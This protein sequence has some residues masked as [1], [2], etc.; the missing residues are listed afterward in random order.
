[1]IGNRRQV[2]E[3]KDHWRQWPL[4]G[5]SGPRSRA[6]RDSTPPSTDASRRTPNVRRMV[7]VEV[8]DERGIQDIP[9]RNPGTLLRTVPLPVDEI[10]VTPAAASYVHKA[11]DRPRR[12]VVDDPGRGRREETTGWWRRA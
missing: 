1:M 4:D 10:L 7:P 12:V 3:G 8:L 2:C 9:P 11:T 6:R 5:G